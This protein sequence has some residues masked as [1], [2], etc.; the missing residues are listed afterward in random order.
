[1][2]LAIVKRNFI[3]VSHNCF[4]ILYKSLLLH[5][6]NCVRLCF[7]AGYDFLGRLLQ[8]D[9]VIT[10]EGKCPSVSRYVRP[11]IKSFSSDF[12]KIWYVHRCR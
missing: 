9:Q 11:S 6:V 7:G 4:V 3:Y 5:A 12:N 1:M 10:L 8:V 2:M